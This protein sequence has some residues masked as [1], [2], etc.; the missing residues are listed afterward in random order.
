MRRGRHG[1]REEV[2]SN[3]I[4][5]MGDGNQAA[6]KRRGGS[7]DCGTQKGGTACREASAVKWDLGTKPLG[8]GAG[9]PRT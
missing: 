5:E 8:S 3:G 6:R 7:R 2:A 1:F 4:W 9:D